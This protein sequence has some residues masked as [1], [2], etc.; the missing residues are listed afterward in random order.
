MEWSLYPHHSIRWFLLPLVTC[1]VVELIFADSSGI[2][3][4]TTGTGQCFLTGCLLNRPSN[5]PK[6]KVFTNI[7]LTF[8]I[9][10]LQ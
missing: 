1:W 5:S 7:S 8:L 9:E 4:L 3:K 10:L 2:G 6:R